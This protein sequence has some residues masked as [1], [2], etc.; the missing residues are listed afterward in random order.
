MLER[1]R[2]KYEYVNR[3]ERMRI[4]DAMLNELYEE[5]G[6][7]FLYKEKGANQSKTTSGNTTDDVWL[8]AKRDRAHDKITHD[9]RNLRR[10]KGGAQKWK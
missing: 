5:Y 4:V 10:Q 6:A 7:R 8:E 2:E 9:F 1:E 3:F